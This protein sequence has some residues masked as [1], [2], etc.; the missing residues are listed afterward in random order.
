MGIYIYMLRCADGSYYVEVQLDTTCQRAS[1]STMLDCIPDIPWRGV[2]SFS[3]GL[4]T[5]TELQTELLSNGKSR[6]GAG[7]RRKH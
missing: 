6:V 1:I 7:P 4:N 2:R 5:S 3:S